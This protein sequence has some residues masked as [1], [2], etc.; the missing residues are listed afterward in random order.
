MTNNNLNPPKSK[1]HKSAS[2]STPT[3]PKLNEPF[4]SPIPT[5]TVAPQ[6]TQPRGDQPQFLDIS[7]KA[8]TQKQKLF[9]GEK[10][11]N[12][13]TVLSLMRDCETYLLYFFKLMDS[14]IDRYDCEF[15]YF[16]LEN[17][18][19]DNTNQMLTDWIENREGN[20]LVYNLRDDYKKTSHGLD[21]GRTGT[22]GMLRNKLVNAVTPLTSEWTIFIDSNIFMD[23]S[24]LGKLFA[25]EPAKN[26][27]GMVCGY[28]NHL[29]PISMLKKDARD[30]LSAEDQNKVVS[31]NHYYDTF[32]FVDKKYKMYYPNCPFEKCRLCTRNAIGSSGRN[33]IPVTE[34]IV[35]VNS[36]FGGFCII[37]SEILND[38]RIRW[39]SISYEI[40]MDLSLCEHFLFCDRLRVITGKK[41]VLLQDVDKIFRTK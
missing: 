16:F 22:I 41:I 24:E 7:L 37:D 21:H 15:E 9:D 29:Y 10:P 30:K 38:P 32:S 5:T 33:R 14:F 31:V 4:S 25:V 6:P 2:M 28:S 12:K 17:D 23:P 1:G 3:P 36:A 8:P 19:K 40:K 11:V 35:E 39:D 34:N 18:S 13:I 20:V 27:Y 26:G